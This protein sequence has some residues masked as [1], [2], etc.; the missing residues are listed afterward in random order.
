MIWD[1]ER[2]RP[3]S[4]RPICCYFSIRPS[5]KRRAHRLKFFFLGENQR[6]GGFGLLTPDPRDVA[7]MVTGLSTASKTASSQHSASIVQYI[8]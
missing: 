6:L 3:D 1:L 2:G 7:W 8:R 4:A 5:A